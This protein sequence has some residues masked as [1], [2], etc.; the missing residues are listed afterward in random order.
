MA[1][2]HTIPPY[3][4][5][6]EFCMWY[7]EH[8]EPLHG[9]VGSNNSNIASTFGILTQFLETEEKGPYK[10]LYVLMR[11]RKFDPREERNIIE[12]I[13]IKFFNDGSAVE[14]KRYNEGDRT[15][16]CVILPN[17]D[18]E[19]RMQINRHNGNNIIVNKTIVPQ[20]VWEPLQKE[21][22]QITEEP[23]PPHITNKIERLVELIVLYPRF[24]TIK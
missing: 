24:V 15:H 16:C 9:T 6:E 5:L 14:E 18:V 3:K 2:I 17:G 12:V 4:N 10:T 23:I 21:L 7:R 11:A 20:I 13:S 1:T 22:E 8:Q 19:Y